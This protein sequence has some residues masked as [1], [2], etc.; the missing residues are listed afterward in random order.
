MQSSR[1]ELLDDF[2]AFIGAAGD[3]KARDRAER[4]LN[5]VL[6]KIWMR[7]GWRCFIDPDVWMFNTVANTRAYALPDHFGRVSG[8]SRTIRNLTNGRQIFPR[9]RSDLEEENPDTGTSSET[10]GAPT[11]YSL[12]GM[13]AVQRQPASTGEA[14]E[15]LSDNVLDTA[16]RVYIEGLDANNLV[17]QRQVTL[18]GTTAV[19]IG[20]WARVLK[21]GKSYPNGTTPTT[22]LTSSEGSVTLRIVS[23]AVSLQV[24]AAYQAARQHQTIVLSPVPDN[25]YSIGVPIFRA[26]ERFA[27][28]ADPLPPMWDNAVFDG[29]THFWRVG[30]RDVAEDGSGFW[31]SLVDLIEYDNAQVAQ[32]RRQ[33][34]PYMGM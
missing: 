34:Q 14:L 19:A 15:V 33:R 22:E 3:S 32:E 28:D 11:Q 13:A 2:L 8:N 24:L 9:D 16:V 17:A 29:M 30:D 31:P 6:E 5:R 7:R 20:T 27:Q 10:P 12:A 26:I 1:K 4:L 25:V 23:G 21:F 18:N